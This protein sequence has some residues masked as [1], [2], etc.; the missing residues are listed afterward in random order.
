MFLNFLPVVTSGFHF[1]LVKETLEE[2]CVRLGII[3]QAEMEEYAMFA[4]YDTG[5]FLKVTLL[6]NILLISKGNQTN[7]LHTMLL[8]EIY[9]H[10]SSGH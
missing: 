9:H 1:Q 6:I 7:Y 3:S 4:L 8:W 5:V 2:I 10:I